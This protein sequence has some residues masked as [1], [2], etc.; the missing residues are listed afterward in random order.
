[1]P[2]PIGIKL[3]ILAELDAALAASG[4]EG[5]KFFT[6]FVPRD[7]DPSDVAAAVNSDGSGNDA[8]QRANPTYFTMMD[9]T[10]VNTTDALWNAIRVPSGSIA[11]GNNMGIGSPLTHWIRHPSG[12]TTNSWSV[13]PGALALG[14]DHD[15]DQPF[16]WTADYGSYDEAEVDGKGWGGSSLYGMMGWVDSGSRM[17]AGGNT[18]VEL[19]YQIPGMTSRDLGADNIKGP[20]SSSAW[21]AG[22]SPLIRNEHAIAEENMAT[23]HPAYTPFGV[24][25]KRQFHPNNSTWYVWGQSTNPWTGNAWQKGDFDKFQWGQ[26]NY[27]GYTRA[28]APEKFTMAY[29]E[30]VPMETDYDDN[31]GTVANAPFGFGQLFSASLD[32]TGAIITT[33]PDDG[34]LGGSNG[35]PITL[36]DRPR[37]G[38]IPDDAVIQYVAFMNAKFHFRGGYKNRVQTGGTAAWSMYV[39]F[40][41]ES[42][43][44]G[45]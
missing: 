44:A 12:F 3:G 21:A 9:S 5:T 30:P 26:G 19:V 16:I 15:D 40:T 7:D 18:T 13:W 32:G 17:G 35:Y 36:Q 4:Y 1:M 45:T 23:T 24:N 14:G 11:W 43:G 6:E 41:S 38:S 22:Q 39:L 10:G 37:L 27:T 33:I 28:A 20:P 25:R 42:G 29:F 2:P 31:D 8:Y 34:E